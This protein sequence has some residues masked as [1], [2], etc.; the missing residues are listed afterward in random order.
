[1]EMEHAAAVAAVALTINLQEA[2]EQKSET[3]GTLLAK[4]KSKVDNTKSPKSLLSSASKRLSG[5]DE[6]IALHLK[7]TGIIIELR[8]RTS[9]LNFVCIIFRFI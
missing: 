8:N 5:K 2:S 7:I 1:M 3:L 6:H 9:L 4:T